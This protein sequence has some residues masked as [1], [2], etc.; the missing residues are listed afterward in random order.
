MFACGFQEIERAE[1]IDL[2]ILHRNFDRTR[3]RRLRRGVHDRV[4][5]LDQITGFLVA[6]I[7]LVMLDLKMLPRL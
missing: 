6:N 3:M 5:V 2:E 7:K 1:R 4:D